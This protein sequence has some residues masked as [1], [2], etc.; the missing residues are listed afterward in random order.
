MPDR[1]KSAT[2]LFLDLLRNALIIA[3]TGYVTFK[4][5]NWHW[6]IAVIAVIPVYVV[7]LNLFGFLT[8]PLYLLTPET[9]RAREMERA[10][11]KQRPD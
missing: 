6:I 4:L 10:L 8:L 1:R 2:A 9:R 3:A 7:M 11:L 5:W